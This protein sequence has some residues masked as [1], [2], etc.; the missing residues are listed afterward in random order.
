MAPTIGSASGSRSPS[1]HRRQQVAGVE[2]SGLV[3]RVK[4]TN[5]LPDIP[6]DS[7]SIKYPFSRNRFLEYK[8]TTLEKLCKVELHTD[9]D[10]G[11]NID[12]I[13]PETYI[14]PPGVELEPDDNA[15]LQDDDSK[16]NDTKRSGLHKKQF[17]FFRPSEYISQDFKQYG[18]SKEKTESR[19]DVK[20]KF[21]DD[22]I[23]KDREEQIKAIEKTFEDALQ[24]IE[25]HY[26][27][28]DVHAVEVLPLLPDFEMWQHAC[29][30]VI[31]DTDPAPRGSKST[32]SK[33]HDI[34][35]QA[36]IRGMQDEDN[37]QFV[38]YFLPTDDTL[39][40]RDS[41]KR[42]G[43]DYEEEVTYDYKL[44]KEY[45][46]NVK[47]KASKGYEENF[48]FCY[49]PG[50]G[51][52]YNELETRIRLSKRVKGRDQKT[53]HSNTILAV[54]HRQMDDNEV[55]AQSMRKQALT[56]IQNDSDDDEDESS[57]DESSAAGSDA[58]EGGQSVRQANNQ[59]DDESQ[60]KNDSDSDNDS[61]G[62]GKKRTRDESDSS[63]DDEAPAEKKNIFGSDSEKSDS[64]SDS[65]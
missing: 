31:F 17:T 49:R 24:P 21:K 2:R 5:T 50:E 47:N 45:N 62:A 33:S 41:D 61:Q 22:E 60:N 9:F 11:V 15:L 52:F 42:L 18:V 13:N 43:V 38:A 16:K 28:K 25:K 48:F 39:E 53:Q 65:D 58:P 59:S 26:A 12:L 51:V 46:W 27:K 29:A 32:Q 64:D 23:Y 10:L 34:M 20:E 40:K 44:T 8:P 55:S 4:Y 30:Q 57:S 3:C 56:H 36:M 63:S 37:D 35:S 7:K 19:I 14:R 1:A 6:F 54:K